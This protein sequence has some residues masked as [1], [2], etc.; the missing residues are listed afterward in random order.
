MAAT[1]NDTSVSE[2]PIVK[3]IQVSDGLIGF[4]DWKQKRVFNARATLDQFKS[5][6]TDPNEKLGTDAGSTPGDSATQESSEQEEVKSSPQEGAQA[7]K[8]KANGERL[9]QLEFNLE[10]A[11]G[12]TIHDY[13][14]LY[15]KDKSKDDMVKAV[16]KLSPEELSELMMAYRTSIYGAPR[17][18]SSSQAPKNQK[19]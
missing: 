15:L 11:L 17:V 16:Q 5:Q 19:L 9:R 1:P 6:Q 13:F 14:A 8:D 2:K 10:I 18:E 7:A 4:K 12:L 3:E